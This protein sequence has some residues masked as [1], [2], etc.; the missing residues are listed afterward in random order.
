MIILWGENARG[1]LL[2]LLPVE[3]QRPSAILENKV[4]YYAVTYSA[5]IMYISFHTCCVHTGTHFN[6][7][8]QQIMLIIVNRKTFVQSQP[9]THPCGVCLEYFYRQNFLS[10]LLSIRCS[11]ATKTVAPWSFGGII[12]T[13]FFF[14]IY[15]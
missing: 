10:D 3:F 9:A 5:S 2:L 11:C 12:V 1:N 15:A 7:I 14:L 13:L 4:Y 8:P 6:L